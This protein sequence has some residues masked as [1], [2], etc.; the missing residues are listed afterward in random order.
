MVQLMSHSWWVDLLGVMDLLLV[1]LSV[2]LSWI[3]PSVHKS[4]QENLKLL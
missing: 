4:V 3:L 1:D 2:L